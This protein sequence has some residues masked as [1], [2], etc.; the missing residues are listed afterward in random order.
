MPIPWCVN[1]IWA[2]SLPGRRSSRN[3]RNFRV[4]K[5][6]TFKAKTFKAKP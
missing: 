6:R 1:I 5:D 2:N 3:S 4:I